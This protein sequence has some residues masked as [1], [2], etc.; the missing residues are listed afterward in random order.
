MAVITA[1]HC[2][3]NAHYGYVYLGSADRKAAEEDA[4][5][6]VRFDRSNIQLHPKDHFDLAALVFEMVPLYYPDKQKVA[7]PLAVG[8]RNPG[9]RS[10]LILYDLIRFSVRFLA[11]F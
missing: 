1:K 8:Q 9:Q 2:L 6:K 11:K 7:K 4:G 3:I 10:L 5:T